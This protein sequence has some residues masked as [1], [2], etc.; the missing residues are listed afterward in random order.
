MMNGRR[1]GSTGGDDSDRK[2][3]TGGEVQDFGDRIRTVLFAG[4]PYICA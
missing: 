2:H 4:P 1:S 3:L